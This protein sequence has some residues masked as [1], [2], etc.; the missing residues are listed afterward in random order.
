MSAAFVRSWTEMITFFRTSNCPSCEAIQDVLD[1][2][3]MAHKVVVLPQGGIPE[4]SMPDAAKPPVLVD[5]DKVI[6]GN[7]NIIAYLEELKG[8]KELWYKYQ[9]DVCYCD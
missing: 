6:Q 7:E 3:G 9:S 1:D 8:F 2:M 4:E 5:D